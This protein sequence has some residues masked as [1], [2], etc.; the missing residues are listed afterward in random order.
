MDKQLLMDQLDFATERIEELEG[1]IKSTDPSAKGYK[2]LA[3]SYNK[4]QDRY[5][6]IYC[7]LNELDKV[8]VEAENLKLEQERLQ[9]DIDKLNC[10]SELERKKL[11]FEIKKFNYE[12]EAKKKDDL[13][14]IIFRGAEVVVKLIVPLAGVA[15]TVGLGKLAY[16]Q[17]SNMGLCDGRVWGQTK[18]VIKFASMK[19]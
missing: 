7:K 2:E 9:F 13:V 18:D 15:A 4:W 12:T 5:D 17:D 1:V 14:N 16:V 6:D 3:D 10:E 8:D 11:Q 19:L